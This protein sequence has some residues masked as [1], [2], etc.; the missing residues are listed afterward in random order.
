MWAGLR[1]RDSLKKG[2]PPGY[3]RLKGS[4]QKHI[5]R[6]RLL[7]PA[8]PH[9][10]FS[11][12]IRIRRP[13]SAPSLPDYNDWA[14]IPPNLRKFQTAEE[15]DALYSATSD[16][17]KSVKDFAK[18][19]GLEVIESNPTRRTIVL[20]GTARQM[21]DAFAVNLGRYEAG[22]ESYRG[23]DGPTYLPKHL[24]RIVE[25]VFG[26]DNRKM[27]F[28]AQGVAG[29]VSSLLTPPEVA[30]LYGFPQGD[31]F[32]QTIGIIEFDCCG[33]NVDAYGNPTDI[34][35]YIKNTLKL[36]PP[37]ITSVSVDGQQNSPGT[38]SDSEVALDIDVA[39]SIA[40]G[41]D[42]AVYFA[43]NSERGWIDAITT[44]IYDRKNNPSVLSIS[45]CFPESWWTGSA[46]SS[47]SYALQEAASLGITVFVASG[48]YGSDC[49][50]YDCKAHV[51]YPSSDPYVTSCGGTYITNAQ[52]N[53]FSEWIWNDD[54]GA[55]GGGISD[56]FDLP[57]WQMGAGVPTS[58]NDG[59]RG[60]GVPDIAGNASPYSGYPIIVNGVSQTEYGTSAVA[61]L[62][63]GLMAVINAKTRRRVGYLNPTLYRLGRTLFRDINDGRNNL[64]KTGCQTAPS[65]VSRQGWDACTGLGVFNGSGLLAALYK[66]AKQ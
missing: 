41:A 53:R 48:D 35:A 24:N 30:K 21:S 23:R 45:W 2:I 42:I 13:P 1:S 50:C 10:V 25:G 60:R 39:S 57:A 38:G 12:T 59:R 15:F 55:T 14:K 5:K 36:R 28:R 19:Q 6:A 26:L 8:D 63:A 54:Q 4:S 27:A 20:S 62:Y 66:T 49:R 18:D 37:K 34:N 16:D 52:G 65:Y 44:A 9:E 58:A 47:I 64:W 3:R 61:P 33:Y 22:G 40:Q 32:G 11:V 31:A 29:A 46:I 56:I 7:G 51:M 43:P 17:I